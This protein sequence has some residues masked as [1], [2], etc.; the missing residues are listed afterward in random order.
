MGAVSQ[1]GQYAGDGFEWQQND[2]TNALTRVYTGANRNAGLGTDVKIAGASSSSEKNA[3]AAISANEGTVFATT[4]ASDS[5]GIPFVDPAIPFTES[6][7]ISYTPVVT[8]DATQT[9][10]A[11]TAL[12]DSQTTPSV[13]AIRPEPRPE[14]PVATPEELVIPEAVSYTHLTLPTIYSV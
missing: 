12:R 6:E 1:T 7:G 11:N 9:G 8:Y 5:T 3:I 13:T 4:P 10:A 14:P 2:N